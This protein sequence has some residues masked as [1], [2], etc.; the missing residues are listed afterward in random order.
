MVLKCVS[1]FSVPAVVSQ[2]SPF[3]ISISD[4]KSIVVK[5][6]FKDSEIF[7]LLFRSR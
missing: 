2:P 3:I 1:T 7:A 4:F 5:V 6:D